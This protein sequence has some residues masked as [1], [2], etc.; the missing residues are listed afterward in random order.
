[1]LYS[2]WPYP[3]A[4]AGRR[5]GCGR[6]CCASGPGRLPRTGG[7]HLPREGCL[8]PRYRSLYTGLFW[9]DGYLYEGTGQN[10]R[11]ELRRVEPATGRVL[12]RVGLERKYFGEGIAYLGGKIYQLTWV[13]GRAF[14][15]DAED[16]RP[17]RSFVY[18]GEGW[19]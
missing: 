19:G 17:L 10:G 1:M 7:I 9:L 6:T 5:S 11:S 16:F 4:G 18:D 15:Y 3:A 13:A 14:V 8:S 12:Q 2:R